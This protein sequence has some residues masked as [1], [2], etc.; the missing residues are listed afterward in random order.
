MAPGM[1]LRI[2][3]DKFILKLKNMLPENTVYHIRRLFL[4]VIF[5]KER[6]PSVCVFH[7]QL[8]A[9]EVFL[10]YPAAAL[11]VFA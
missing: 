8:P 1:G 3:F 10:Q 2:T 9:F 4:P 6:T 11:V 7:L 5:K